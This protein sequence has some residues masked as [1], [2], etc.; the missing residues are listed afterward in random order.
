MQKHLSNET[1]EAKTRPLTS[2]SSFQMEG[3]A[4]QHHPNY[5]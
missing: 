1:R 4:K 2:E 5:F 3:L